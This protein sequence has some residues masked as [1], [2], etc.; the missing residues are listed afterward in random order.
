[1]PIHLRHDKKLGKHY[2]QYGNSGKKYYFT[3]KLGQDNAYHKAVKQ[4]AAINIQK[5]K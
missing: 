1:M 3:T 5:G 4:T 2:Y